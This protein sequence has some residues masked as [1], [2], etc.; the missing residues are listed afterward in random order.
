MTNF[1]G[2]V[3]ALSLAISERGY[4]V[5]TPVQ[6]AV[7]DP[8]VVGKDLIVSAQTGSGKTVAFGLAIAPEILNP[9]R[10]FPEKKVPLGLVIAPTRELALQ[11]KREFSWLYSRTGV[12]VASCVGGMDMRSEKRSLDKGAHIVFGT[13]G[14][15]RDH[16]ERGF[17][18]LSNIAAVV[19]D[20][21]DEML[22][23]GFREELE[24]ILASTSEKRRTVLFSATL[25]KGIAKL[26]ER[27]QDNAVRV[28]TLA[29]KE[30][31][32]DIEYRALKI[33]SKDQENAIMNLLRYYDADNALVFCST[34]LGVNHLTSRL[35]NRGFSV[36]SLS[37][38]LSQKERT[39]AL[40]SLRDGRAKVCVATDVA[41]RGIDLP[42]LQ[43]VVHADLPKNREYLL[44]RSG[45]TGRAG[46]KGVSVL[47]V[48]KSAQRKAEKL[49][50][51]A[52]IKAIWGTPPSA[53]EILRRD[54]ERIFNDPIFVEGNKSE[55]SEFIIKI[56]KR[57]SVEEITGALLRKYRLDK[58]APDDLRSIDED[59]NQTK[60]KKSP[61]SG[62]WFSVSMGRKQ[63]V[64]P[65]WLLGTMIKVG[66]IQKKDI[67]SI[68]IEEETSFVEINAKVASDL[69][70]SI[71]EN[72][73]LIPGLKISLLKKNTTSQ[74]TLK[75]S[76]GFKNS[77]DRR[78]E[79]RSHERLNENKLDN[80]PV[81]GNKTDT[82]KLNTKEPTKTPSD[83]TRSNGK[84]TKLKK[85]NE[86]KYSTNKKL[87]AG[88]ETKKGKFQKKRSH[89]G[90]AE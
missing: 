50:D 46:N 24:F 54:N 80:T 9:L 82:Q 86:K 21:A 17:L 73:E 55:D 64:D 83:F 36:V 48:P 87:R 74:R 13:P 84:P 75:R 3:D 30:Q 77:K 8:N 52:N 70:N 31:H 61:M 53:D 33:A 72:N 47:V 11:V 32:L 60:T 25:S 41:A 62:V 34:R 88:T 35:M 12:S 10:E 51:A 38:E 45:R 4:S 43:L 78:K 85:A 65:R 15:L 79:R 22:D 19:L 69:V 39:H 20:E 71:K 14:R 44:H 18:K 6:K 26:A 58:F 63:K 1:P 81:D 28:S 89:R 2:I 76:P 56:I 37:G 40:Q 16:I 67:G 27:Y 59:Q 23:L 68:T 7:L 57:Y 66:K 29:E 49:L 5:L 42:K 90:K